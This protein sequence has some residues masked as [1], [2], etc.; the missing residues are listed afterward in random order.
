MKSDTVSLSENEAMSNIE[1]TIVLN[2]LK[3]ET[4]K[5]KLLPEFGV[6]YDHMFAFGNGPQQF[7]LMGMI[8][9]PMPWS[10]MNKANISSLK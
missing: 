7:S 8:T 4:E 6:K 3:I 10:S 5:L 9:I 1:K 2:Q